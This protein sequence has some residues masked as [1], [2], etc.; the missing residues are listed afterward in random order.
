VGKQVGV[1]VL[2]LVLT[3]ALSPGSR[4]DAAPVKT[5]RV[6]LVGDS[7]MARNSGYG[8]HLCAWFKAE[9]ECLNVAKGGRSSRTFREE[10]LWQK[11][12]DTLADRQRFEASYVLIQFGHNDQPGRPERSTT[13]PQFTE[14]MARYVK[15][16]RDAGAVPVLV[17]PL[18]RR[19][20]KEGK[21]TQDLAPWAE[22][23]RQVAKDN[24]VPLLDLTRDSEQAVQ[25]LGPTRSNELAQAPPSAQVMEAALT[26]T[27]IEANPPPP[28]RPTLRAPPV[29]FDYTHVGPKGGEFFAG[30]VAK[31]IRG[32]VKPLARHLSSKGRALMANAPQEFQIW[33]TTAPGAEKVTVKPDTIERSKTPD[34]HDRALVGILTPTLTVYRPEHPDGSGVLVIPGGAYLRV[35]I[36]KEGEETARRLNAQGITAAVL[37]YRLPGDGWA[38]GRDAPLQDAQRAMRLMRSGM[39]GALDSKRIGV[40]GFSAGGDVAAA[41]TLRHDERLYEPVDQADLNSARPDFTVLLY[42]A[43][44]MPVRLTEGGE[45]MPPPV[46]YEPLIN[47]TTPPVFII[48]AADDNTISVNIS[49]N[50]F[51]AL[52]AAKVPAEMHIFEEGAHGFG[53]RMA[54]GKP[55]EAWPD[56]LVRWG[57]QHRFFTG[58]ATPVKK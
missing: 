5:I 42:P 35:V 22:A 43:L 8:E 50:A 40:L 41:V 2:A 39:A 52:K 36:D 44:E 4:A 3:I 6:I 21:I 54:A 27:T 57:V 13:L 18:T 30:I 38:A 20:F 49:L 19:Q 32:T 25:K 47:G 11:V 58:A 55:V 45:P 51:A 28:T 12:L 14:N 29:S 9:V 33:R 26:G 34:R 17:T 53:V 24:Q 7:T 56:L 46:R 37:I 10:G 31:E 16:A 15:E 48:H 1:A 23:T